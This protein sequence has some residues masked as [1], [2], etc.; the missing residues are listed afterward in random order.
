L[1]GKGEKN[2][3]QKFNILKYKK[4]IMLALILISIIIIITATYITT[5]N[6]NKVTRVDVLTADMSSKI[7]KDF[8]KDFITHFDEFKIY[9]DDEEEVKY[10]GDKLFE[11]GSRT[12]SVENKVKE[13]S[14]VSNIKVT[15]GMGANWV[16]YISDTR[17]SSVKNNSSTTIT[18]SN[19]EELFPLQGDLWFLPKLEPTLYVMVEWSEYNT[20]YYAYYEYDYSVYSVKPAN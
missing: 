16:K 3:K 11:T 5:Y 10:D 6:N 2:M 12:F 7:Q 4:I 17:T 18:I 20:N 19:I 1:N 14:T 9:L 15:L 8:E 13:D